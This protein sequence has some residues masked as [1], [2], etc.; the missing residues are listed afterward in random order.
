[1]EI[2]KDISN[3]KEEQEIMKVGQAGILG[4]KNINTDIKN[5]IG[6]KNSMD[7]LE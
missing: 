5:I 1:M 7:T 4:M 2:S 6:G 3:I